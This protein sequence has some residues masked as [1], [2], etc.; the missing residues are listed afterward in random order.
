M[1]LDPHQDIL[2]HLDIPLKKEDILILN[3]A[4]VSLNKKR[5]VRVN[6]TKIWLPKHIHFWNFMMKITYLPD[7]AIQQILSNY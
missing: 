2:S 1:G 4:L 3:Y 7:K 5:M 6:I